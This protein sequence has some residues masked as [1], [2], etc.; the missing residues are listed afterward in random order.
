MAGPPL[1][2]VAS[3]TDAAPVAPDPMSL[4]GSGGDGTSGGMDGLENRVSALEADVKE[5]R[6]DL[7]ALLRDTAELKGKVGEMSARMGELSARVPTIWQIGGVMLGIN[8]GILALGTY[9]ARLIR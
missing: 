8:A 2:V 3:A 7:K 9:L 5:M 6:A 1:R 4:K